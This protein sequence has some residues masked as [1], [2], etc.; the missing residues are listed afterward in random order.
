[1]QYS[2]IEE[3]LSA[4]LSSCR[5]RC[6]S[7]AA[8]KRR[9]ELTL[10]DSVRCHGPDKIAPTFFQ[11]IANTVNT[12]KLQ[13]VKSAFFALHYSTLAILFQ[14]RNLGTFISTIL[15]S[16]YH[17]RETIFFKNFK[18]NNH[19]SIKKYKLLYFCNVKFYNAFYSIQVLTEIFETREACTQYMF[20]TA[21]MHSRRPT[22]ERI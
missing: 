6:R 8:T 12:V 19:N 7:S 16:C 17:L 5:H 2:R 1:M 13:V 9:R 15:S 4:T 22:S 14:H 21:H 20:E 10:S 11:H 18:N 3:F